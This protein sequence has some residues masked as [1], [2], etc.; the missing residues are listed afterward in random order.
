MIKWYDADKFWPARDSRNILVEGGTLIYLKDEYS[1]NDH[2]VAAWVKFYCLVEQAEP[3]S[4][5]FEK[6]FKL[7]GAIIYGIQQYCC[8]SEEGRKSHRQYFDK[9]GCYE[10]NIRDFARDKELTASWDSIYKWTYLD[11]ED[12]EVIL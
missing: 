5:N 2:N 3:W 9:I 1:F 4:D 12:E 8:T 7:D 11:N 6:E 10:E